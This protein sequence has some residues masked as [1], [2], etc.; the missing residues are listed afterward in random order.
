MVNR[1][2]QHPEELEGQIEYRFI[3]AAEHAA[4]LVPALAKLALEYDATI[5]SSHQE[6]A[7]T[8]PESQPEEPTYFRTSMATE[9]YEEY[10]HKKV[11]VITKDNLRDFASTHKFDGTISSRAFNTICGELTGRRC[12]Q[13]KT[14]DEYLVRGSL[15]P[16][17]GDDSSQ[18]GMVYGLRVD[19][20]V[21]LASEL[22]R[23]SERIHGYGGRSK[24]LLSEFIADLFTPEMD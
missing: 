9:L 20:I 24:D 15:A 11:W 14:A 1:M 3:V 7:E 12:M 18:S 16:V 8:V 5:L 4:E 19:T 22:A 6:T 17:P 2:S 10:P 23:V 21:Q 13:N